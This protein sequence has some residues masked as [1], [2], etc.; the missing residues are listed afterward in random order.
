MSAATAY[1]VGNRVA[2]RFDGKPFLGTVVALT[3]STHYH[4][5]FDDGEEHEDIELAEM[6][7]ATNDASGNG[8]RRGA[9]EPAAK[10]RRE[11]AATA[12]VDTSM[13]AAIARAMS[14]GASLSRA[15]SIAAK[16]G[17]VASSSPSATTGPLCNGRGV[18]IGDKTALILV[19]NL[20]RR[21]DRLRRVR[22][23]LRGAVSD[24][25]RVEAEDG[26]LLSWS[27]A[28][29]TGALTPTALANAQ[30][31]EAKSVPTIC[32]S[33]GSFSPH[34]TLAAV[35]CAL[36]HRKAWERLASSADDF[37]LILEDD[38][39]AIAIDL[40]SS[41]ERC[42][43]ALPSSWQLCLVGYHESTGQLLLPEH[44]LRLA[45]L[46]P[47]E[48][49]TGLFGYLLRRSA[50]LELLSDKAVFPL[51]HQIDVQL[52]TRSWRP[53]SRFALSPQAVLV[54]APKS[55]EGSCDTDVRAA[56]GPISL[57]PARRGRTYP[58]HA[59]RMSACASTYVVHAL[60]LPSPRTL[61]ANRRHRRIGSSPPQVQTLGGG[62]HGKRKAHA[63][64]RPNM[65]LL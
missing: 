1:R 36:S 48:G 30:W 26:R 27:D 9:A 13:D 4:V 24:W 50:A 10:K 55:E 61:L 34:L 39:S 40:E 19:I 53:M 12:R 38:I 37:A 6:V 45:E 52:G 51:D 14:R 8:G 31:S 60:P 44:R 56:A 15:M 33:T 21:S 3:S 47:E 18:P 65:M 43:T 49:Q 64:M 5:R 16:A 17:S 11:V 58:A 32:T 59:A 25:E 29:V 63:A 22:S 20:Q 28:K 54:H 2:V 35:G 46:A 62:Q 42:V 41:L 7:P 23:V 57:D